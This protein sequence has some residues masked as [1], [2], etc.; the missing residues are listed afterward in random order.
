MFITEAQREFG[1]WVLQ[2]VKAMRLFLFAFITFFSVFGFAANRVVFVS[3]KIGTPVYNVGEDVEAL[4]YPKMFESVFAK[5]TPSGFEAAHVKLEKIEDMASAVKAELNPGDR[6]ISVVFMGHGSQSSYALSA[7]TS[8]RGADLARAAFQAL[9]PVPKASQ[10]VVYFAACSCG[11]ETPERKNLQT[12]FLETMRDLNEANPQWKEVHAV[13]H[14]DF[15]TR[16]LST[17]AQPYSKFRHLFFESGAAR[18]MYRF[19]M[20][21]FHS[22]GRAA[23][24]NAGMV[25]G[26]MFGVA[27]GSLGAL[28]GFHDGSV[29]ATLA[30]S[31]FVI[32]FAMS[33]L[34]QAVDAQRFSWVNVKTLTANVVSRGSSSTVFSAIESFL[35]RFTKLSCEAIF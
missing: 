16:A 9:A 7:G 34:F 18:A 14:Q 5:D 1:A 17:I 35:P 8:Y 24:N 22:L 15:S 32:G 33:G 10:L 31:G 19:D 25:K 27:L 20:K 2:A 29:G 13:A 21:I 28:G 12:D 23:L 4:S 11:I 6:V 26:L 30:T 3:Q